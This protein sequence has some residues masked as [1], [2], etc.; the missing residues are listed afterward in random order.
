MAKICFPHPTQGDYDSLE[1]AVIGLKWECYSISRYA[2]CEIVQYNTCYR[3]YLRTNGVD[4]LVERLMEEAPQLRETKVL[5]HRLRG[6]AAAEML[7]D[8]DIQCYNIKDRITI[9]GHTF[10]GLADIRKHVE[11]VGRERCDGLH[12]W[13]PAEASLYD[14]IHVGLL[15]DCPIFDYNHLGKDRTCQNYLFR[16]E[17]VVER[18]MQEALKVSHQFDFCMVHERIPK[19]QLPILYYGGKGKYML[20][21]SKR[22]RDETE[23]PYYPRVD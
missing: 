21:A 14:D 8:Y 17:P 15:E 7:A 23:Q 18:D 22:E 3:N 13:S 9:L 4:S 2:L 12:T 20:L 19:E 6:W 5:L 1:K 11:L 16:R 10:K